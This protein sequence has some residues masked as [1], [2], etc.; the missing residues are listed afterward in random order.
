MKQIKK[1]EEITNP[2]EGL[3]ITV[4]TFENSN[5]APTTTI[6]I[7]EEL[8]KTVA[9]YIENFT[10]KT[11]LIKGVANL[12]NL[13]YYSK[14]PITNRNTCVVKFGGL[15]KDG[16]QIKR[17]FGIDDR[18]EP[19]D[20]NTE[21]ADKPKTTNTRHVS[22]VTKLLRARADFK[23]RCKEIVFDSIDN[24]SDLNTFFFE[25]FKAA[26]K[27]DAADKKA[28]DWVYQNSTRAKQ[29]A[30]K[31]ETAQKAIDELSEKQKDEFMAKQMGLSVEQY[32]ILKPQI[33]AMKQTK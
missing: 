33:E 16:A 14:H 9:D 15:Y 19:E 31:V 26:K 17:L 20:N 7:S 8:K 13:E 23:N 18:K 21:K 28:S 24:C 30:K 12:L 32:S 11:G 5:D 27:R 2:V 4:T 1:S 25:C 3:K 10:E 29:K 22:R 6:E